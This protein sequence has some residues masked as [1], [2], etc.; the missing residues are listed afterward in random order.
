MQPKKKQQRIVWL[1]CVASLFAAV[2]QATDRARID[3]VRPTCQCP[4][5]LPLTAISV[6]QGLSACAR[7][8]RPDQ[9]STTTMCA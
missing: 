9:R 7:D 1:V 3:V 5:W 2:T 6:A 8:D 4:A